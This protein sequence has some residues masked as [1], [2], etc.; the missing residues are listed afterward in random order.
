MVRE[1]YIKHCKDF[2]NVVDKKPFIPD[3]Y[4]VE[5]YLHG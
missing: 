4:T 3:N 1:N 2:N 5:A